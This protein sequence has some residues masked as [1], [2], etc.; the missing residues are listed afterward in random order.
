MGLR[1]TQPQHSQ[2]FDWR[3][4]SW[5][6][7]LCCVPRPA[8]AQAVYGSISG[9][10]RDN[11]DAILPGVTVTITSV[12]RQTV[13][14]VVSNES[15]IYLKERLLPGVYEVKA[16][17]SGFKL[18]VVPKVQVSVDSQ[19]PRELH[20]PGRARSP[21]RSRS[22]AERRSSRRIAPMWRRASTPKSS[23]SC[24]CSIATSRSSFS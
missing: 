15:G 18:A 4:C 8:S 13:D 11:T 19:T 12:E 24:R 2:T 22:P 14:A 17:L 21:R 1:G 16:E 3:R 9:T 7:W 23:P 10:V 20:A 5:R 6:R